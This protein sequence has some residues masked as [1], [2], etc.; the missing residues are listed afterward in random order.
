MENT[1]ALI[2]NRVVLYQGERVFT[3]PAQISL[4]RRIRE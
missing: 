4:S 3:I 1:R 2:Q